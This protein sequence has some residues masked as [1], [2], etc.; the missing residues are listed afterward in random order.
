MN[1]ITGQGNSNGWLTHS[2]FPFGNNMCM[3]NLRDKNCWQFLLYSRL[4]RILQGSFLE[5]LSGIVSRFPYKA[6]RSVAMVE[7]LHRTVGIDAK[8]GGLTQ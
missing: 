7:A 6:S 3:P 4:G 1:G 5:P 8:G 2:S